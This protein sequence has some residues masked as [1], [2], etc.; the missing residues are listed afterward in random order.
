MF[1][2]F[3]ILSGAGLGA[4]QARKRK[5][6]LADTLQYGAVYAMIGGL[7]GLALTILIHRV[8]A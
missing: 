2:I 1:V 7:S 8:L 6:N 4:F 5:G 3:G